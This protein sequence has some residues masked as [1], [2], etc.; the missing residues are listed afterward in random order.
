VNSNADHG[1]SAVQHDEELSDH[2]IGSEDFLGQEQLRGPG[3]NRSDSESHIS[4]V[5]EHPFSNNEGD[6]VD[7]TTAH[8]FVVQKLYD[9]L[10]QGFY[11]C[12]EEEHNED[13]RQHMINVNHPEAGHTQKRDTRSRYHHSRSIVYTNARSISHA[14]VVSRFWVCPA[15]GWLTLTQAKT[16][17]VS[18]KSSTTIA[19]HPF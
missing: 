7:E 6:D 16:T 12:T 3:D 4:F 15:S 18:E 5:S 2:L 9:E 13:C 17:T 10:V 8:D 1:W 14:C 19:S 11:G